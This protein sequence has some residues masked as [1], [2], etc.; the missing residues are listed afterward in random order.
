MNA[1]KERRRKK[2]RSKPTRVDQFLS[3]FLSSQLFGE[4]DEGTDGAE[5]EKAKEAG[6]NG[7]SIRRLLRITKLWPTH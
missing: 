6:E 4:D 5:L 3:S 7:E 1:E 2:S